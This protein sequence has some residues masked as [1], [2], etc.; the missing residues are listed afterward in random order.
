M[1]NKRVQLNIRTDEVFKASVE[2]FCQEQGISVS[3]FIRTAAYNA[4]QSKGIRKK[5][6]QTRID[7]HKAKKLQDGLKYSFKKGHTLK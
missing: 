3:D 5:V 6:V 4:M 2:S 7:I 1:E